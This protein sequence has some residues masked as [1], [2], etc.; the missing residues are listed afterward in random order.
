[1][2]I[3]LATSAG[4]GQRT[5]PTSSL[6]SPLAKRNFAERRGLFR[7]GASVAALQSL[8]PLAKRQG[9]SPDQGQ[10]AEIRGFLGNWMQPF[11]DSAPLHSGLRGFIASVRVTHVPRLVCYLSS[12]TAQLIRKNRIEFLAIL[13]VFKTLIEVLSPDA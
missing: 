3:T 6:L 9:R 10:R 1:M 7:S 5:L 2:S 4:K 11:P 12:P 13:N 8:R